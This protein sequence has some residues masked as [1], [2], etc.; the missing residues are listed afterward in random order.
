MMDTIT[1]IYIFK[2]T[3]LREARRVRVVAL[4]HISK[5]KSTSLREARQR[6]LL[7]FKTFVTKS[8]LFITIEC[9]ENEKAV[10]NAIK[11]NFKARNLPKGFM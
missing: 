10:T 2:S 11:R 6:K 5:F 1:H 3:S 8:F 7:H 9:Y 4:A